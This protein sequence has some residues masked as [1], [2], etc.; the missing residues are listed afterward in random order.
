MGVLPREMGR[1]RECKIRNSGVRKVKSRVQ[2]PSG[3]RKKEE[4]KDEGVD[5]GK[6]QEEETQRGASWGEARVATW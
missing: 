2:P 6:T 4:G 5:L 1:G 3:K